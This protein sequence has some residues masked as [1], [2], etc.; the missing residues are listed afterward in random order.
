MPYPLEA[1][2][3]QDDAKFC[4]RFT[5]HYK[6]D[7]LAILSMIYL[8]HRSL[9]ERSIFIMKLWKQVLIGLVIGVALGFILKE[10][11]IYIK[12]FGDLFIRLIKMISVP[13]I[14]LAIISGITSVQDSKTLGRIGIKASIAYLTTTIFAIMIGLVVGHIFKP[15]NGIILNFDNAAL[16]QT[17]EGTSA[18]NIINII[19]NIVPENA[20]G[21]MSQGTI[22]QVVFFALFT[23]I[24]LNTM[25]KESSKR[26]SDIFRVLS[27]MIFQM[28]Y[29]I[30]KLSPLAACALIAWVVGTQGTE[31]LENLAKL[32]GCA[33]FAFALQYIIFGIMIYIWTRLS[34]MPFYKKSLEY[35]S[36]AFST[37]SSKA[38][39]PTTINVCQNRLGISKLSSSFVLPLGASINMD[40]IAIYIS[41]C[42]LFFAQATGKI[43]ALSDYGCIILT[44]TLGAI[45]GAGIPGGTIVML[46]MVL[47]SIGLPIEGIGL[48][49]G[50]DR[51]IDM[52]R[53]TI[54][55]TGDA[56]VTLCVD[57]SEGL[58][59]EEQYKA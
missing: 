12:P 26:L 34:P 29:I 33:Y 49:V 14:F 38:A 18:T 48:I 19:L 55:I 37:S 53:T 59:N 52:M 56:A 45:G 5:E 25:E 57:K 6:D 16:P 58:L 27:S 9:K 50:I 43:L 36:L 30:I 3:A 11:V 51:I 22:L 42:A 31:I 23:G 8:M 20:I 15:G 24:T 7:D 4:S 44:G 1:T 28:V 10:K 40:G 35:Q 32:V 17:T 21:A 46:P 47:G 39:L 41:L 13:L 2:R 54:S